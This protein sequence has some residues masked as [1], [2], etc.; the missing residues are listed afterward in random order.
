MDDMPEVS[1][2]AIALCVGAA[3]GLL[4]AFSISPWLG[5]AGLV[6]IGLWP[7][8]NAE[9]ARDQLSSYF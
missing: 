7:R 1:A 4:L 2:S 6:G 9:P 8:R 3:L 5:I